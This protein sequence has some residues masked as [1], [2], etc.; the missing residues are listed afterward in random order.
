MS[1][2]GC[3]KLNVSAGMDS[4]QTPQK[5]ATTRPV[6]YCK[7]LVRKHVQFR[8]SSDLL[9]Y[10]EWDQSKTLDKGK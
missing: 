6:N 5:Q 9:L 8:P 2:D 10:Q 4:T 7:P 1:A 3:S